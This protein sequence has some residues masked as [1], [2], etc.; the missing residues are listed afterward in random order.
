M[1]R[2]SR[3]AKDIWYSL[4]NSLLETVK[5]GDVRE[6]FEGL[7]GRRGADQDHNLRRKRCLI[8]MMKVLMIEVIADLKDMA[9]EVEHGRSSQNKEGRHLPHHGHAVG[10]APVV[11]GDT[12]DV[13][14]Q[15]NGGNLRIT[16]RRL[17]YSD[18]VEPIVELIDEDNDG[19]ERP[20]TG[21]QV[22]P[23]PH[24]SGR[25]VDE[26]RRAENIQNQDEERRDFST[27]KRRLGIRLEDDDLRML[28]LEWKKEGKC[29]E[30]R[31]RNTTRVPPTYPRDD[32]MRNREHER[33]LPR[34]RFG[35]YG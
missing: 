15:A 21:N 9:R 20:R 27:L 35:N 10:K 23:H 3:M 7:Q 25:T 17:E 12:Q 11:Q 16:L 29:G 14:G 31:A 30:A 1:H 18:G 19:R 5:E 26:R 13:R 32:R 33:A 4:K 34:G 6:K 22:T 24:R 28:L 8:I 2:S